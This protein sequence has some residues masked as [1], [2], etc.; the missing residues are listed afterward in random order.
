M[1]LV[2]SLSWAATPKDTLVVAMG[3]D[4]FDGIDPATSGFW[5]ACEFQI[6]AH[7]MP[8]EYVQKTLP[9]GSK[10]ADPM[11]VKASLVESIEFSPDKKSITF[12]LYK[13][14]KFFNGDPVTAQAVKYSYARA[15]QIPGTS[16]FAMSSILTVVS[17]DQMVVLDDYT[18]RFDL[19]NPNPIFLETLTLNNFGIINP[20]EV[21]AHK[22]EKD[23]LARDWMK[24]HSTGSG[25]YMLESWKP[26]VEI[27][28][29]AN[30]NHW[31]GKPAIDRVI[32][33]VVPSEQDRI[34]LLKNGDIDAAY[35]I[36]E[37]DIVKLKGEKGIKVHSFQTMAKEFIF[38]NSN[39]KPFNDKRV[40][41]AINHAI[42]VDNIIKNVFMG[43][44]TPNN[45]AI[46][47]GMIHHLDMPEYKY[48]P[49]LA[50]KLLAEAGYPKGFTTELAFR[51]G[52]TIQEEA[53]VYVQADLAKVGITANIVTLAPATFTERMKKNELPFGFANFI[54]YVNHP[55]YHC[56]WQYHGESGYNYPR[57]NNPKVNDLIDK[58]LIEVDVNK[59]KDICAQIQRIVYDDCPEV[60]LCQTYYNLVMRDNVKGYIFFPDRLTRWNYLHKE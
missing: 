24:T 31:A 60:F 40:R 25:P 4:Y 21:E 30:P 5:L 57:Y 17:P 37:R 45:S 50:M 34:L 10:I 52:Y 16:R 27:T 20:K 8:T 1:V 49:A 28:F 43:L 6:Q 47:K 3:G 18:I 11:Q 42:N 9:D 19:K 33:K 22:T 46:P 51:I 15:L 59:Q 12:R 36:A 14:R 38:M 39:L 32:Y 56:Y 44:G 48:D 55:A 23:P 26:G 53:S 29:K 54:P 35:N 13:N 2:G 41:Q 58:L 7:D